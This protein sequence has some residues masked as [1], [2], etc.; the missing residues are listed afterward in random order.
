MEILAKKWL[1]I[2]ANDLE[3]AQLALKPRKFLYVA[4]HSQQ[5]VEKYFKALY[6]LARKGNPPYVH[7]LVR[8]YHLVEEILGKSSVDLE[9][10]N[11]LNVYYIASRYPSYKTEVSKNLT[12]T[13]VKNFVAFAK[14]IQK[15][16]KNVKY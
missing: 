12:N 13:K 10:L 11:E 3:M 7:D 1:E 9:Q 14:K 2:A 5:A 4:F 16:V 8:L 6:V 15:C